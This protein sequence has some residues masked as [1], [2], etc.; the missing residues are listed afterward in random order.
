MHR[1]PRLAHSSDPDLTALLHSKRR[2]LCC[3]RN[4]EVLWL[5]SEVGAAN[6][7]PE[8]WLTVVLHK[9]RV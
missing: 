3:L 6:A 8:G 7:Q 9:C 5:L 2:H 4:A 1:H